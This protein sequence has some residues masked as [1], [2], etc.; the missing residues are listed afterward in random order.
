M[1]EANTTCNDM[2]IAQVSPLFESVPPRM[3]GGT[4]RVVGYLTEALVGMGHEVT[5]FASGDSHTHA[6]LVEAS[7][8]ALRLDN[9]FDAY[10][11]HIYQLQLVVDMASRFDIIHFH[12]DYLHY[13]VSRLM[14]YNHVTTLHGRLN[15]PDLA[16][17]YKTFSD[18]PV[19]SISYNQREPLPHINWI[20]NVYHGLPDNLYQAGKGNGDYALFIG[21]ISREKR[22]D[23]AI[24]ITRRAKMPLKIAAKIDK[25][26]EEYYEK[27]IRPLLSQPHID[28]LGEVSEASKNE[29]IGNAR[30]V[31]FPIDWP[32]PFGMV[33]IEALA[34]GTPVI[35]YGMGSVPEILE[36]GK[37]GFIVNSIEEAVTALKNIDQITRENCR[38]AFMERFRAQRM[39]E[40]YLVTY[41]KIIDINARFKLADEI[42]QPNG[43]LTTK[44]FTD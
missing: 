19:I 25:M 36:Q 9:C 27:K 1:Y 41:Q 14:G 37:S 39:A 4:E 29:L 26:D 31:L 30:A 20:G 38:K 12:T 8:K 16:S 6:T 44:I 22:L 18:I 7:P 5:L 3:Y 42:R 24:E 32:E 34:C 11:H 15:I 40:D 2:R 17:L 21:R 33:L 10:A 23:R 28:F 13:P 35:A 43:E